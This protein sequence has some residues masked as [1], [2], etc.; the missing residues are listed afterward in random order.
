MIDIPALSLGADAIKQASMK[1]KKH[2]V[3]ISGCI[4]HN[5]F[6]QS[7]IDKANL[8]HNYVSISHAPEITP[9]QIRQ[10]A[11]LIEKLLPIAE[12]EILNE[13]DTFTLVV[14]ALL[15]SQNH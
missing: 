15:E 3:I 2:F 10:E 7:M 6:W 9:A 11:N 14:V 12:Y 13:V 4:A 1:S 5:E 8:S